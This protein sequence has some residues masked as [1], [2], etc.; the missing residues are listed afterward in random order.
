[1]AKKHPTEEMVKDLA[2]VFKKHNWSGQP[3][4][5]SDAPV[6]LKAM[7]ADD[8]DTDLCPDGSEPQWVTYKLPDGTWATK[9]MCV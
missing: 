9:K 7:A 8:S 6:N 4:G 5:L 1:M 2:K 3:I